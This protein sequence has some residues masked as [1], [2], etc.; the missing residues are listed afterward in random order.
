MPPEVTG[1]TP[2]PKPVDRHVD[3]GVPYLPSHPRDF[4]D[5]NRT[6]PF[7]FTGNK[8][9]VRCV[10]SSQ[11]PAISNMLL[12]TISA[13]SFDYLSDELEKI[14]AKGKPVEQAINQVVKDTLNK[15]QRIIFEGNNYSEAWIKEAERRG[16]K[17]YKTTPEVLDIVFNDKNIQLLERHKVM[18]R[19]EFHAN[20]VVDY[21]TYNKVAHLEA[22]SIRRLADRWIVPATVKYQKDLLALG[23]HAPQARVKQLSELVASAIKA[24]DELGVLAK[25]LSSTEAHKAAAQVALKQV[26]PKGVELRGYLDDLELLVDQAYWPLPTYEEILHEKAR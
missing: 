8:F 16:V 14:I 9:E 1:A 5:R 20:V 10:G 22:Q 24:S 15:H 21:E 17:N 19:D 12:N 26:I 18:T 13:D 6:S 7:A 25:Q 3:L 2:P 11:R 4:T 23:Q